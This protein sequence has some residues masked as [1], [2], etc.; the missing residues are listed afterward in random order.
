MINVA[1]L[2]PQYFRAILEGRKRTEQRIRKRPDSVLEAIRPGELVILLERRSTRA[3]VAHVRHV[4]RF[5]RDGIHKYCIRI[6]TP[7]LIQSDL[8]H[9]QGWHRRAA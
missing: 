4:K 8:R 3:L 7:E 9:L 1:C 6:D 5:D 2:D